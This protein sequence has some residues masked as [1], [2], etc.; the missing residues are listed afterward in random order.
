MTAGPIAGREIKFNCFTLLI[1]LLSLMLLY[2]Y[3]EKG[4]WGPRIMSL[5]GSATLLA[6]VWA[7][8]SK[9]KNFLIAL[10]LAL[11]TL[12]ANWSYHFTQHPHL[13]LLTLF[14][15]LGFYAYT[16]VAILS[17]VL[18]D[19]EVTSDKIYGAICGYLL[20][21]ISWGILYNFLEVI[22]PGS[23]QMIRANVTETGN[24]RWGDLIFFSFVTLTTVGYGD[25]TPITAQTRSLAMVEA[26][27]GVLYVATL[28]ARLVGLYRPNLSRP[29]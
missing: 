5:L 12:T 21:G 2:P 28:V 4:A 26:I 14:L 23:F 10:W 17:Y 15:S 27:T 29:S 22:H 18:K 24:F 19:G 8:H 13:G 20:L 16:T 11:P 3:L 1:S 7:V 9:R 25:I 6:G